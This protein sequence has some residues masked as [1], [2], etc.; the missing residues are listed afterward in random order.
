MMMAPAPM[1]MA[2]PQMIIQ[3]QT[4]A[5]AEKA[6]KEPSFN[7][8]KNFVPC[9]ARVTGPCSYKHR[10]C[11]T[12]VPKLP[13]QFIIINLSKPVISQNLEHLTPLAFTMENATSSEDKMMITINLT[14]FGN[15]IS[16]LKPTS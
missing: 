3:Q 1:M 13:R 7:E 16:H 10:N 11:P 15:W 6:W 14:T 5:P 12:E 2:A 8:V 4:A 9:C